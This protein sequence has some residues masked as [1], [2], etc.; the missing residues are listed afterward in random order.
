MTIV[1]DD[2][3][4]TDPEVFTSDTTSDGDDDFQPFA[5]PDFGDDI[6]IA[7]GFHDGDLPLVQIPAPFPLAAFPLEDL[8]LDDMSDDDIDLFIE[9]PPEDAQDGRAPVDD[10]ATPFAEI[11]VGDDVVIPLVEILVADIIAVPLVEIPADEILSDHS[12]PDSF[13]SVSS[14]TLHARGMQHY[15]TDTDSDMAMSAAPIFPHDFDPDHEIEFVPD[16]PPFEAP[17]IPDDQLFDIPADHELAPADPEPEIAPEPIPAHDPLP[18]HDHVDLP[19]VAPPL[20]DPIHVLVDR[21]PFATHVDPD[22]LTPAMGGLRTTATILLLSDQLL[23]L[24]HLFMHPLI[25]PHFTHTSLTSTA[26]I[27]QSHFFR[28]SH[29]PVQGKDRQVSRPVT[30]LLCQQSIRSCN[31]LHTLLL[32]HLYPRASHLSGFRPT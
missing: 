21:A 1:S 10:V 25:S 18:E 23:P 28:I 2:E 29:L 12:G 17:V 3:I 6:P 9:G 22:M 19:V 8:P 24:L 4:A 13:Q 11:P 30:Y 7:D 5:L 31:N 27:Y 15:P 32:L 20:P 14:A 26:Q 16:E